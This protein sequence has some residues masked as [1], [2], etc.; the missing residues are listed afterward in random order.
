LA[1]RAELTELLKT[2]KFTPAH[3]MQNEGDL[4]ISK[5]VSNTEANAPRE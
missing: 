1:S 5:V 4:P 2:L 3:S